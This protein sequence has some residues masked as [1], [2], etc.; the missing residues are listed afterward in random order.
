MSSSLISYTKQYRTVEEQL[1]LLESRGM[2]VS[3]RDQA[4]F[5]LR[6]IG[7]YRLSGYCY[8]FRQSSLE[9]CP[10]T[11]K[12]LMKISDKFRENT[13][14]ETVVDLYVFDKRLKML[15]L[16][17]VERIEISLRVS[18]ALRLGAKGAWAHR[19]TGKL[20]GNFGKINE[21]TQSTPHAEWLRKVDVTESKSKEEFAKRFR[22]KYSLPM[23]LWISLELWDFGTLSVLLSNLQTVDKEY[24]AK[25]YSIPRQ[26]LLTSW[27]RTFNYIRNV[28]AHHSR[29]W[30]A[31]LADEP[32]QVKKA[33]VPLLEHLVGDDWAH[34]R[35]YAAAALA[36]YFLRQINPKTDWSARLQNHMLTLPKVPGIDLHHLGFPPEWASN[37]L[38]KT[39][40]RL[41]PPEASTIGVPT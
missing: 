38:W 2:I 30:N 29:L 1:A 19:D 6:R 14:F 11:N 20:N 3:D 21:T 28:C 33:E 5:C 31:A 27:C 40:G 23:P 34:K 9:I 16:D 37:D 12:P 8:P 25:V 18:V 26:E 22:A 35:L 17:V 13:T 15:L 36:H 32:K 41:V 7:Y 24:I 39:K 4:E 10:L